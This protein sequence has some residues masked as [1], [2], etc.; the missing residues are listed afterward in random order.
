MHNKYGPV[1]R[2]SPDELAFSGAQAFRDIYGHQKSGR[3][4]FAKDRKYYSGLGE[5][6]LLNSG[7]KAY[8]THL[9][10]MLLPGFSDTS[11]RKQEAVIQDYLRLMV[12]RLQDES[13]KDDGVVDLVQ[14]FNVSD[15]AVQIPSTTRELI[16]HV[17]FRVRC[18][19]ASQ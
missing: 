13:R 9:R 10:K 3:A 4:E 7:D 12:Q 15:C 8:H 18:H 14:W 2:V 19:W 5:P 17:V 11:L 1:V 6:T 16:W